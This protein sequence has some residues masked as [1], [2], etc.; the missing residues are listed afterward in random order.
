MKYTPCDQT[1]DFSKAGTVWKSIYF[2]H[3]Q[4]WHKVLEQYPKL[5][6]NLAH[7]GGDCSAWR[8]KL[9]DMIDSG[10]YDNLYTDISCRT[11]SGELEAIR[12]EYNKSER[13]QKRLMYGSDL[14]ILLLWSDFSDFRT[15]VEKTFPFAQHQPVYE[16]NARS[17]LKIQGV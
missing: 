14:T 5:R 7:F 17:F 2:N 15:G 8:S 3:P 6:L 4:I 1:V 9:A 13:V 11:N 16:D 10:K 12:E